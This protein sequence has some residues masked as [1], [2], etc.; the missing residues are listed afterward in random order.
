[1]TEAALQRSINKISK[2]RTA[3][4]IAHRLSTVRNADR[5]LVLDSGK[6]VEDGA[7]DDLVDMNGIYSRMWAVQTGKSE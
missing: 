5:I 4:I 2:D 1:E 3:V 7:H 6:I